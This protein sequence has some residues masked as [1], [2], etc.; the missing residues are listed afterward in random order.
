MLAKARV[1]RDFSHRVLKVSGLKTRFLQQ[2]SVRANLQLG[3]QQLVNSKPPWSRFLGHFLLFHF[4]C[5]GELKMFLGFLLFFFGVWSSQPC[6]ATIAESL[7][8]CLF[9][10]C[11]AAIA[12]LLQHRPRSKQ[13]NR[14]SAL[15][16]RSTC[17]LSFSFV[18]HLP[19]EPF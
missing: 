4:V 2:P 10:G 13:R 16:A 17:L 5:L 14:H 9:Q 3:R 11:C 12:N 1:R 15:D 6:K 7:D 19:R 8:C 18:S